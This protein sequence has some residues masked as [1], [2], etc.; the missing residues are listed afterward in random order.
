MNTPLHIVVVNADPSVSLKMKKQGNGDIVLV[1]DLQTLGQTARTRPIDVLV[2]NDDVKL[3]DLAFLGPTLD[4]SKTV[5]MA[6]PLPQVEAVTTIRGLLGDRKAGNP[7]SA[8]SNVT[9]EDYV[10]SKFSE[11]VRAMKASSARSLYATLIR[12][13]E[14]PLIELALRETHGNQIQAAQLLGLNRNTLRKKISEC[15]ISIK[16]RPRSQREK[17]PS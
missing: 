17:E 15:K 11:F 6:G 13:V 8:R 7:S 16:R 12:A 2:L 1:S 5:V 14:R 4:L 9:L 10:E 3:E